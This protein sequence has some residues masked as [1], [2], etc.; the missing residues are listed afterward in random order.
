MPDTFQ[1]F[2]EWY[3]GADS[4]L[5]NTIKQGTKVTS[6][7]FK[8]FNLSPNYNSD[9]RVA[10]FTPLQNEAFR[11][12]QEESQNPEYGNLFRESKGAIR[13]ALGQNIAPQLQPY[14]DRG[15]SNPAEQAQQYLNPYTQQVVENI[16]RAGSRNLLENILPNVQDNF[17]RAGQYGSTG[18]QNFTNRAIR[19]AQEGIGRQQTEALQH[20][21]GQALNTAGQANDRQ[22]QSG[23]LLG[24]ALGRDIERGIVGGRELQ[25]LGESQQQAR[26]RQLGFL[27][28]VGSQQQGQRQNVLNTAYEDFEKERD[29]PFQQVARQNALVRGLPVN[30]FRSERNYHPTPPAP[31]AWKQGA[32]LLAGF[33]GAANQRQ[34]FAEGG[35]V[36]RERS[37]IRHYAE[38][39]AVPT[40]PI[41]LGVNDAFDTTEINL[42]RDQAAKFAQPQ[43]D[44]FWAAISKAGF[45]LAANP[46]VGNVWGQ[47]GQAGQEGLAEYNNQLKTQDE[48]QMNSAKINEMV[49][50]TL[51][52]QKDR[53]RSHKL[54]LSKFE[55]D[56]KIDNAKLGF[57]RDKLGLLRSKL[58]ADQGRGG[59]TKQEIAEN[60]KVNEEAKKKALKV[61]N[62]Y[63]GKLKTLNKLE[64]ENEKLGTGNLEGMIGQL[65]LVG[66]P[67][68]ASSQFLRGADPTALGNIH[69]GTNQ[70]AVQEFREEP[71]RGSV[72][73]L[74]TILGGKINRYRTKDANKE[75]IEE[76]KAESQSEYEKQKFFLETSNKY[77]NKYSAPEIFAAYDNWKRDGKQ[78]KPE[79]YLELSEVEGKKDSDDSSPQS[80]ELDN[81]T[82]LNGISDLIG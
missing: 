34:G 70:L 5:H 65:P 61:V 33:T 23:Q 82:L 81:D 69:T 16:G 45:N 28:E 14:L 25:N 27:G 30:E 4:V 44:P 7:P 26:Q 32:G 21:Y 24:G 77:K 73:L 3:G 10:P 46:Q 17:I 53:D 66:E 12:T 62:G 63:E 79:D 57:E 8:P 47:V 35:H 19:D 54:D 41:Q 74:N 67:L 2:P 36:G 18:H 58:E 59:K 40:N 38:G 55:H 68:V 37:H 50:K 1:G 9:N 72:A 76:K 52:W 43:I 48:R 60:K 20:G 75:N 42:L 31:S 13:N 6:E 49:S 56:K 80:P 29:F 15:N 64:K 51:N 71:G 39:G 78:H 22:I 11:Q